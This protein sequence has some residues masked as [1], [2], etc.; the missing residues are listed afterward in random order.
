LVIALAVTSAHATTY[1]AET[2]SDADAWTS[3][4]VQSESRK[5]LGTFV[6]SNG[7]FHGDAQ[8]AYGIKTSQDARFYGL[9]TKFKAPF[10]NK[11]KTLVVQFTVK[12]EQSIDCGGGYFK[13]LPSDTDLKA[14]NGD[15]PYFV[16]F[17]PDICGSSRKVHAIISYK[18]ENKLINKDIA[19]KSDELTH[20]FTFIINPD[21][22]YSVLVDNVEEAK[23]S[24]IED[25]DFLPPKTIADPEQS[26]PEDWVDEVEIVDPTDTKPEGH[27]DIAETIVDPT[28]EKPEDWDDDMDGEWEAPQ[29][30]NPEFKG[31]WKAKM[32]PNPD[33]KGPWVHPE[34]PNPDFKEDDEIYVFP[35][36]GAIG[37]DLWQVKSGTIFD[38]IFVGDDVKE[39]KAFADKHWTKFLD[40]EKKSKE[41]HDE[42][43]KAKNAPPA[44]VD[45]ADIDSIEALDDEE[46]EEHQE[47]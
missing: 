20:L 24:L 23:G 2:F 32:I 26:K 5:D 38:N 11:D 10:S 15:S 39:A 18:G 16:M 40:A 25:W 21:Q 31:P 22:T 34:I 37:F 1:F 42:E 4:W 44:P 36:V 3:R 19:T 8:E 6:R 14:F 28:A 9:S 46:D 17:G 33:Y 43:L 35:N 13:L 41:A 7:A 29:V 12:H 47:L 27:D 30:P 45:E